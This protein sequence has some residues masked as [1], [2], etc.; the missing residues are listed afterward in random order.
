VLEATHP[1]SVEAVRAVLPR[2]RFA[3]AKLGDERVR[4]SVV[5]PFGFALEPRR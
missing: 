1:T 2:L 3:P 5:I 4:Q